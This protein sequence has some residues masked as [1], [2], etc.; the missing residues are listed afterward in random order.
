MKSRRETEKRT[1]DLAAGDACGMVSFMNRRTDTKKLPVRVRPMAASQLLCNEL[2]KLAAWMPDGP[3]APGAG[4]T[5]R[6][7]GLVS[8]VEML[9]TLC[10]GILVEM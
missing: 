2:P 9:G 5:S 4:V 6:I 8:L 10:P 7:I 3:A 1:V